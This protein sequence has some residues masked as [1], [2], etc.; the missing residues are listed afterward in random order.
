ML[1]EYDLTKLNQPNLGDDAT[2]FDIT[3]IGYTGVFEV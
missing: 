3:N 1:I 2:T